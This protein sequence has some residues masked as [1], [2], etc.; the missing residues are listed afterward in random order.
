MR[1]IRLLKRDLA[2]EC[3]EWVQDTLI[4]E[5]Q[6][7]KIC[8]RYG[9]NYNEASR[10]SYGYAVL[11]GLGYLFIGLA[12]ITLLSAN[13]EDIPRAVRM[14]GLLVLTCCTHLLALKKY[15]DGQIAAATG[16]FFLGSLFY[17]A[18][19]MLIAQ[20]Y[21]IDEHYPNGI[22]WWVTGILPL[23]L[24]LNSSALMALVAVL[25]YTWFFVESGLHYY[26]AL[27]PL[28]LIA[29]GWHVFR[30]KQ[31]YVLFLTFMIGVGLWL[32]YSLAWWM[33]DAYR[34]RFEAEHFIFAVG[35]FISFQGFAKWLISLSDH[36]LIDY[37]TILSLWSLRFAII[38]LLVFSFSWYWE[39]LIEA[40]WENRGLTLT[41]AL[42]VPAIGTGLSYL[43]NKQFHSTLVFSILY[44]ISTY[45]VMQVSDPLSAIYF[46]I[47]TNIVLVM[48]G[49]WL[50]IRGIR[51]NVTHYFFLGVS[52]ILIT[53]FLRYIDLVGDYIGA[54]ILFIIF[55]VILLS[56][57]RFWKSHQRSQSGT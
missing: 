56:A 3:A 8:N 14:S 46:Q 54:A 31:S 13:W 36:K 29:L 37:G 19:I 26:P 4:S 50:I 18:S 42:I 55:A 41:L 5:D 40:H 44:F 27:F 7:V 23:A 51:E 30:V 49:I 15:K 2:K 21:H 33:S 9:I 12:V 11:V 20:I 6:A 10:S 38:L 17:G 43:G 1:L 35:L 39:E 16:F 22:F 57:A 48:T 32:E 24:L 34:F 28:F 47:V 45:V 52:S 53:G 25:S